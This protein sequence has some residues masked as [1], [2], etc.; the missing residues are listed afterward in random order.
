MRKAKFGRFL[1]GKRY[2]RSTPSYWNSFPGGE[3]SRFDSGDNAKPVEQT[4]VH[5]FEG[6]TMLAELKEEPHNHRFAG[7]SGEEIP[8]SGGHIHKIRTRTDFFDH[9]HF[10]NVTTDL[11]IPVGDDK[12][13]HFAEGWTSLNDGHKHEFQ[14][15]TLIDS[16]LIGGLLEEE[17]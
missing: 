16:P 15:A 3:D 11:Q 8:V 6:S 14:F 17:D 7:V 1:Q 12:H 4:H 2:V 10:I 5:E 9:F 13:V